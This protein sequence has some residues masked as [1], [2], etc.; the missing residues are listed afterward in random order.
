MDFFGFNFVFPIKLSLSKKKFATIFADKGPSPLLKGM[1]P[2]SAQLLRFALLRPLLGGRTGKSRNPPQRGGGGVPY[3][4]NGEWGTRKCSRWAPW[5]TFSGAG[6]SGDSV[7][8]FPFG[9]C[10]VIN[11]PLLF[12]LSWVLPFRKLFHRFL[13][14][15]MGI[16]TSETHFAWLKKRNSTKHS[17]Q[18]PVCGCFV[19]VAYSGRCWWCHT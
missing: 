10:L 1:V 3:L 5:H 17:G 2:S 19:P 7:N 18:S 11:F 14:F 16:K 15:M 13:W 9:G 8:I 12:S 4:P 6:Y